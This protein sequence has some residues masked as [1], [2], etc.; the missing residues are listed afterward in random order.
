MI[1]KIFRNQLNDDVGLNSSNRK[2]IV[3]IV[4][5][6]LLI[7]LPDEPFGIFIRTALI[8]LIPTILWLFLNHFGKNWKMGL[9]EN[10]QLTRVTSGMIAG[11]FF[12]GAYLNLT[13]KYH[14]VCTQT[15]QSRDGT[16]CVGDYI[17]V[18]GSDLAG[19]FLLILLGIFALWFA[20]AKHNKN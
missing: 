8:V 16:E 4:A 20:L 15:V 10:D 14:S 5:I 6:L 1:N 17:S 13:S 2:Y 7:F 12:V 18:A 19:A 9:T 3:G 11:A